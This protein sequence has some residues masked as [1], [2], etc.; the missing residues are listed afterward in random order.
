MLKA[1]AFGLAIGAGIQA[2]RAWPTSEP[3]T[4]SAMALVLIV[5]VLCA[6]FGGKWAGRGKGAVAVASAHAE[7]TAVAA[8]QV[9]LLLNVG[10]PEGAGGRHVRLDEAPWFRGVEARPD[11]DELAAAMDGIDLAELLDER[12][13][14]E[15]A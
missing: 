12:E 1:I 5:G 14:P 13:V 8:N 4:P 7:A 11:L 9:N 3:A 15:D 2:L 6:F 10:G